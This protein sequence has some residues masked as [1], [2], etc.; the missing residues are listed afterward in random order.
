VLDESMGD[1]VKITVIATG[2]RHGELEIGSQARR[3][4]M[5]NSSLREPRDHAPHIETRPPTPRFASE[6]E[7]EDVF[8]PVSA[9]EVIS[10]FTEAEA[11]PVNVEAAREEPA[12]AAEPAAVASA[13][14]E[15]PAPVLGEV[16][17]D[18][19]GENLDIPAFLRRGGL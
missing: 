13:V 16:H 18:E 12:F 7:D 1:D 3:E 8:V 5:L 4:H 14:A 11:M 10:A 9:R 15:P 2:F 19:N 17:E 6:E